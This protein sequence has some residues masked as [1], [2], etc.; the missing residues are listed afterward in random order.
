[1]GNQLG[2]F[3]EAVRYSTLGPFGRVAIS[4]NSSFSQVRF[5]NT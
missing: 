3:A 1:M 5:S 2:L 4:S